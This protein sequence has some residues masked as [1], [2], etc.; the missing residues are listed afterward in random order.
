MSEK[1]RP[2]LIIDYEANTDKLVRFGV[3]LDNVSKN[4]VSVNVESVANVNDSR[5]TNADTSHV[6]TS[7][8]DVEI[9]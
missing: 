1:E 3:R 5:N 4:R 7:Q 6:Q 8:Q 9:Y 2:Q